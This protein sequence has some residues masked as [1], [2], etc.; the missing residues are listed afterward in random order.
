M[1]TEDAMPANPIA[2][3]GRRPGPEP[4]PEFSRPVPLARFDAGPGAQGPVDELVETIAADEGER[5]ALAERFGLKGIDR[6][7]ATV[8][9][10]RRK[11][12]RMVAVDGALSADVVQTCVV[13]LVPLPAHVEDTFDARFTVGAAPP[14]PAE[15]V[16]APDEEEP[17][18]P[19]EGDAVDIGELTAQYLSLALDPYP[20]APGA[21]FE[22]DEDEISSDAQPSGPFADLA[23]FRQTGNGG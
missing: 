7:E 19:L 21:R 17:P 22:Y 11:G 18:E 1:V 12:G 5:A 2:E 23:R 10:Q 9:L 6:L 14:P 8:R 13:T 20:R 16:I 3:P 15:L 4:V